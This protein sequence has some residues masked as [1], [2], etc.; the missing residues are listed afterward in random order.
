[1]RTPQASALPLWRL[2]DEAVLRRDAFEDRVPGGDCGGGGEQRRQAAAILGRQHAAAFLQFENHM[3]PARGLAW[4]RARRGL[5]VRL[6]DEVV[7]EDVCHAGAFM[8]TAFRPRALWRVS[9]TCQNF[10]LK[11]AAIAR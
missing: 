2:D 6:G 9:R 7:G 10:L 5:F 3:L 4:M 1:M 8:R 11:R